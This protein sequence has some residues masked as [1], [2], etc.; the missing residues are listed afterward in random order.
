V[1]KCVM[2]SPDVSMDYLQGAA[3]FPQPS[4]SEPATILLVEDDDSVR[5]LAREILTRNGYEVIEAQSP[6]EAISIS[7]RSVSSQRWHPA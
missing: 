5:G 6:T 1:L 4:V 2:H 7:R 3:A